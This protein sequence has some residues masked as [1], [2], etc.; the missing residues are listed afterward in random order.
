MLQENCFVEVKDSNIRGNDANN[1]KKGNLRVSLS[2]KKLVN[3]IKTFFAMNCRRLK[4][5]L[6]LNV[7]AMFIE[8]PEFQNLLLFIVADPDPGSGSF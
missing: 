6:N 5:W 7:S 3:W 2:E 8:H 1:L 4:C